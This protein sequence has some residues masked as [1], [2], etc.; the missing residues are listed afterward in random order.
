[1]NCEALCRDRKGE[2]LERFISCSLQKQ[3]RSFGNTYFIFLKS[4]KRS[5]ERHVKSCK[6]SC[7]SFILNKYFLNLSDVSFEMFYHIFCTFVL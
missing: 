7:N 2:V 6:I 1:M 5:F 3:K 4:C